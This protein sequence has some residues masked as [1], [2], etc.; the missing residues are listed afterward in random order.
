M[1][2]CRNRPIIRILRIAARNNRFKKLSE[3]VS[4]FSIF[5]A[6]MEL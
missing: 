3:A 5:F 2:L 6:E 1:R 4:F